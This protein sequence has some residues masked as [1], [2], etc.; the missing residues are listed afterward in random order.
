MS[1]SRVPFAVVSIAGV[2]PFPLVPLVSVVTGIAGACVDESIAD[3]N[4]V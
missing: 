2:V 1:V 3:D 4:P